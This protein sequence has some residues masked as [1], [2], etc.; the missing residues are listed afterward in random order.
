VF[1]AFAGGV[2]MIDVQGVADLTGAE[3]DVDLLSSFPQ[4]AMFDLIRAT[5]ISEDYIPAVEDAGHISLAVVNTR[6]GD[7]LRATVI[8]EPPG[9]VLLALVGPLGMLL[10]RRRA[11]G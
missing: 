5:D 11:C 4:G 1:E 3:I 7:I 8:P 6:S 9:L 2:S 10:V